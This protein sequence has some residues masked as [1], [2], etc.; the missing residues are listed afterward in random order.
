M[1]LYHEQSYDLLKKEKKS[2][3]VT[4]RKYLKILRKI[5]AYE[6]YS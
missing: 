2:G 5:L 4:L 6:L 3:N 1:Q